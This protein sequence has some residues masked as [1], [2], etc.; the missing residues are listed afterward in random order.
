MLA[1]TSISIT[2]L[3]GLV[4]LFSF[5]QSIFLIILYYV[6]AYKHGPIIKEIIEK[7]KA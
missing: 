6:I 4:F 2:T 5:I 1:T 3:V 7:N